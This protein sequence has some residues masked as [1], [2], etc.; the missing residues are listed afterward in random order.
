MND[1]LVTLI[2]GGGFLGRYVAQALLKRGARVR[3]AQRD[4]RQAVYLKP[5]GGLGQTQ[6]VGVDVTKPDTIARA[7]QGS[8]AVV[9]LVGVLAGNF[10]GVHVDG[11]AAVAKAA[12]AAGVEALVHI[13]AIGADSRS[14]SAYGRSKGDGEAAVRAAFPAATI[15]RPS[16]VF[17]QEDAFL[18]RFAGMIAK[19]PVVPVLRASAKFQPVFAADVADAI[20]AAIATPEAY[21]GETF[22]LGG[23]D[24]ITMGALNRWLAKTI[25]RDVSIVEIPDAVGALI[26]RAGFLPGAPITWDQW[27]MLQA[28]NVAAPGA[29]GL[30]AFGITATPLDAVAPGWLVRFR[31]AGRFGRRAETHA[32]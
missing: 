3:I 16:I 6:F 15:L 18:N 27:Q 7:V 21:A 1:K 25:G 22:D 12:A 20:A 23:P 17:G 19:S 11:A 14:A 32:A 13:S 4:P 24:V 10:Q 9:N 26:A 28:D 2:G 8:D 31:K 30:E 29:R 5:L